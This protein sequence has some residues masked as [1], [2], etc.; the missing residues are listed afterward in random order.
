MTLQIICI[1]IIY[2]L[3][4]LDILISECD[5]LDGFWDIMF[6]EWFIIGAPLKCLL[7]L[8]LKLI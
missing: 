6:K 3:C 8:I 4:D 7:K 2:T 5:N 1:I